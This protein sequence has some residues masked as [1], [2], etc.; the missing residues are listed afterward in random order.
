MPTSFTNLLGNGSFESGTMAPWS[1]VN[2]IVS[3]MAP[4]VGSYSAILSGLSTSSINQTVVAVPGTSY[5]VMGSFTKIHSSAV[6]PVTVNVSFYDSG[7]NLISTGLNVVLPTNSL[8][9]MANRAWQVINEVTTPA[10]VN[11][12]F[13][14]LII[15]KPFNAGTADV[16][17]DE[18]M[19]IESV[20]TGGSGVTG[21]TG[22]T[23]PAGPAGPEGAAGPA[24]PQGVAGP[25][26]PAGAIGATGPIGATGAAGATGATG[27][28]AIIP[29][30]SGTPA[31]L[32][33]VL[34]GLLGT[35]S[36]VGFGSSATGISIVGGAIDLTGLTNF[37]FSVPDDGTITSMAAYLST[38]AAVS[39]IGSTATIT[40][41]LFSSSTP[42]DTFVPIPGAVVTLAPALT[43]LISIGEVSSGITTGLAI[44]VTAG[45]RLLLVF[46]A[47][48]TAGL[49]VASV[50]AGYVSAGI[51]FV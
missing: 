51:K 17:L 8:P 35:S 42:D 31:L 46:S 4:K 48:I 40:A 47:D 7:L 16:S 39:L 30:A 49:D 18:M 19:I 25:A 1:P 15:Y 33:T 20:S 9:D 45:T 22:A 3:T 5:L 27:S 13:A 14:N 28:G 36:I 11:A 34:G 44:P 50:I 21:P 37:A 32:T 6:D 2:A 43:G 10:P 38:S 12:A 23:G 26:G 29:Y 41:Q 24:G